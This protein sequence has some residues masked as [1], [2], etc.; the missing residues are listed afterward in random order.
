MDCNN[1]AAACVVA[2]TEKGSGG[3]WD[4][5]LFLPG[6]LT[7]FSLSP[8]QVAPLSSWH[9]WDGLWSL[10]LSDQRQRR[11]VLVKLLYYCPSSLQAT[12]ASLAGDPSTDPGNVPVGQEDSQSPEDNLRTLSSSQKLHPTPSPASSAP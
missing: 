8:P 10:S 7:Q 2:T 6:N 1:C 12:L 4:L 9:S 3:N 11:Q 5:R